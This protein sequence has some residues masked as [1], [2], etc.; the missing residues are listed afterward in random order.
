MTNSAQNQRFELEV[1]L[2]GGTTVFRQLGQGPPVLLLHG[3]PETHLCWRHVAPVLAE[4]RTVVAPDLPGYG[5]SQW[6]TASDE[7]FTKRAMAASMVELMNQLGHHRF[8]I[9]GHDRGARVSYRMALDHPELVASLTVIDIVPTI[10]EWALIDGAG[11]VAT[12]HWP[13]LAQ[14]D[15]LPETLIGGA[16]DQWLDHLLDS[17]ATW[18]NAIPDD[19]RDEYRRCFRRPDVIAGTCADYRAGAAADLEHDR[20]DR[21]EGRSIECEVLVLASAGRG[22]LGTTWRSWAD[23]VIS[24]TIDGGHFLP[25]ENPAAVLAH[26]LPF[27][28][29]GP[30]PPT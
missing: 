15:H 9:V 22:D 20:G 29:Q 24:A 30:P 26:L 8:D 11:S 18:P 4:H 21:T 7:P 28:R 17:W 23:K 14:P 6:P 1:E 12:F 3:Y 13:F 25:E 19:V 10:D 5:D 2:T 16:P 27:L